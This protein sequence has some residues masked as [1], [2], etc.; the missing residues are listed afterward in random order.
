MEP[1]QTVSSAVPLLE[2]WQ[3]SVECGEVY[4]KTKNTYSL[5]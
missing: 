4:V 1:N 3:T 5:I 2:Y